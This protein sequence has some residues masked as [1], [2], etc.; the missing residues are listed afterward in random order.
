MLR[1]VTSLALWL[2]VWTIVSMTA[3]PDAAAESPSDR[4]ASAGEA[5]GESGSAGES[6]GECRCGS[7]DGAFEIERLEK[8]EA[9][10]DEIL[11]A[12]IESS[13]K[14]GVRAVDVETGRVLYEKNGDRGFNPA[15]N[16][17]L[18]TSAA[19]LDVFGPS[20]TFETRLLAADPH[21]GVVEGPLYVEGEGEPFLLFEDFV[22]WAAELHLKG[23]ERIEGDL[24]I[25]DSIFDGDYLPPAFDQKDED[26]S[27]RAPIGAVSV[28][29]NAVTIIVTPAEKPGRAPGVRMFPPNDHVTIANEAQTVVGPGQQLDFDS[30]ADGEGGTRIKVG[31]VVGTGSEEVRSRLRIDHPPAYAGAVLRAALAMVGV[32]IEGKVR[33][34]ETPEEAEVVVSHE[35]QPLSYILLAMNKWSN[36]FMAEQLFRRLGVDDEETPS[37]WEASRE[38]LLAFIERAGLEPDALTVKNGSGLYDGNSVSPRQFTTLLTYMLEHRAAPEFL[39]SLAIGGKDGTLEDRMTDEQV[40]GRVRAKTG[41]LAHVSALSGYVTTQSGRRVA[42]SILLNETPD[43][44]WTYRSMQD[45]IA[46]AL[47]EL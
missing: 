45:E 31:G 19:A 25:D 7:D 42:F 15:S 9:E 33:T 16:M 21:E 11:E 10:I 26:A 39:A 32:E 47:A 34:G 28:N 41:T 2:G 29:F 35:S 24:V 43:K 18:L 44:G 38:R 37:S 6:S 8:L 4:T 13:A 40:A 12:G 46:R 1:S 30:E 36:N 14:V 5:R 3:L 27:Y 20:E 23:V 22:D 17:K